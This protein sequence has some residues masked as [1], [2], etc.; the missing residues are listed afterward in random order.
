MVDAFS[1]SPLLHVN[2]CGTQQ[3]TLDNLNVPEHSLYLDNTM[4]HAN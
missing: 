1:T 2:T 3:D 4:I